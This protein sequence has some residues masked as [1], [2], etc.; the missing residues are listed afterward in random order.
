MSYVKTSVGYR[1]RSKRS[2]VRKRRVFAF[3]GFVTIVT[4]AIWLWNDGHSRGAGRSVAAT[5][6]APPKSVARAVFSP[7]WTNRERFALGTALH[8]AFAPALAGAHQWSLAVLGGDGLLVYDDSSR[9]AVAPASVQKL[10]V[11]ASALD[12]LGAKYRFHTIF[13]ARSDA[14][15]RHVGRKPVARRLRRPVAAEF[16]SPQRHRRALARRG[17]PHQRRGRRRCN[18]ADRS[19]AATRTG[20]STTTARITPRRRA[21]FRSTATRSNRTKWSVASTR[22]S[23]RR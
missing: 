1:R 11:A 2:R 17:A 4:L 18:R 13:A 7:P 12:A 5:P 6:P 23:G 9:R 19:R 3:L 21:R 20:V 15:R 8:D 22:P 16:R 14:R 10:I